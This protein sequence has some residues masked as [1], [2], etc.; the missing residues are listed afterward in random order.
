MW[1]LYLL[2]VLA[3]AVCLV[4]AYCLLSMSSYYSRMEEA[5]EQQRDGGQQ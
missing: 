2:C 1:F 5:A 3:F 4:F